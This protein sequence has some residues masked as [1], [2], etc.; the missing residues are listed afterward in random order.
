MIG[1][2]ISGTYSSDTRMLAGDKRQG[3]LLGFRKGPIL[4]I[5][6]YG[7]NSRPTRLKLKQSPTN[8]SAAF[9]ENSN[10]GVEVNKSGQR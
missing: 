7:S 10:Y 3:K 9:A 8:C 6:L 4:A 1:G 2:M 5:I